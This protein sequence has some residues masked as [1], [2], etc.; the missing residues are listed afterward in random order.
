MKQ[1]NFSTTYT[2]V[3]NGADTNTKLDLKIPELYLTFILI[4]DNI[5]TLYIRTKK[6]VHRLKF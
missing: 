4:K 6:E 2:V 5:A 3:I 1:N